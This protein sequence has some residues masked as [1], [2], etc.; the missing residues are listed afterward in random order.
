[1]RNIT[2]ISLIFFIA[3][4]TNG[5]SAPSDGVDLLKKYQTNDGGWATD[6]TCSMAG[7]RLLCSCGLNNQTQ[8]LMYYRLC[9][10]QGFDGSWLSDPIYTARAVKALIENGEPKTN[11][12]ITRALQYFRKGQLADGSWGTF[13]PNTAARCMGIALAGDPTDQAAQEA[14]EWLIQHQNADGGW[15]A[16][17]GDATTLTSA[18]FPAIALILTKGLSHQSTQKALNFWLSYAGVAPVVYYFKASVFLKAGYISDAQSALSSLISLQKPDGGWALRQISQLASDFQ[19]TA[20]SVYVLGLGRKAG[21]TGLNTSINNGLQW[22]NTHINPDGTSSGWHEGVV[23]TDWALAALTCWLPISDYVIEN[24]ID[25]FAKYG[26][27]G[28]GS[29]FFMA[30]ENLIY[31]IP[32][33]YAVWALSETGD[34]KAYNYA[35]LTSEV[36]FSYQ[37]QDGS[38]PMGIETSYQAGGIDMTSVALLG[39]V[40]CGNNFYNSSVNKAYQWLMLQLYDPL[41]GEFDFNWYLA[42]LFKKFN[43]NYNQLVTWQNKLLNTQNVDGGWGASNIST[44]YETATSIVILSSDTTYNYPNSESAY[45]AAVRKGRTWLL[46]NQLP[47]GSWTW[48]MQGNQFATDLQS[49]AYALWA[50]GKTSQYTASSSTITFNKNEYFLNNTIKVMYYTPYPTYSVMLYLTFPS[51]T[52]TSSQMQKIDDNNFIY[53]FIYN[54]SENGYIVARAES[55]SDAGEETAVTRALL[56]DINY[57]TNFWL[58]EFKM[59]SEEWLSWGIPKLPTAW[60]DKDVLN[61]VAGETNNFVFWTGPLD[62]YKTLDNHIYKSLFLLSS[63]NED[64]MTA[65]EIRLR[66]N[67]TDNQIGSV[68]GITS[69]L[70]GKYSPSA[71]KNYYV[72]YFKPV[73]TGEE[74]I[75]SSAFIGPAYD[76]L[77]LN[78]DDNAGAN[79]MLDEYRLEQIPTSIVNAGFTDY[80]EYTFSNGAEGWIFG[81]PNF[82]TPPTASAMSGALTLTSQNNTNC[83]GYWQSPDLSMTPNTLYR[84]TANVASNLS[85]PIITPQFR[86]RLNTKDFGLYSFINVVSESTGSALP[87]IDK[88]AEYELFFLSPLATDDLKMFISFDMINININ[89][90]PDA[91]LLLQNIK[92]TQFQNPYF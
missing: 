52:E 45:A 4:I 42:Y 61:L 72:L 26:I 3:I 68:F 59:D 88:P 41:T 12:T 91:M 58:N 50:L 40:N 36:L 16:N 18:E 79:I 31:T 24:G 51:G 20:D 10:T 85:D 54:E 74:L 15:G 49:T 17:V 30:F 53:S 37:N 11:Q 28:Y 23:L 14:A 33:G 46:T 47:N 48:S 89:D 87:T 44:T 32:T 6:D 71:N 2:F 73:R 82:V 60:A 81:S 29:Y 35:Q 9:L 5:F 66:A 62:V 13:I 7:Y 19:S 86:L 57:K 77:P 63:N 25:M 76:I 70:N 80:V 90:S 38:W 21:I 27:Y 67:R 83:L 64:P 56:S 1:M 92:I 69:E 22:I 34:G 8:Y 65:P 55:S 43:Y 84:I 78:P 39:V 75:N